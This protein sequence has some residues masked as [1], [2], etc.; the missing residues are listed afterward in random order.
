MVGDIS[1]LDNY[2]SFISRHHGRRGPKEPIFRAVVP[3]AVLINASFIYSELN[4]TIP[5]DSLDVVARAP[6]ENS[7]STADRG[8]GRRFPRATKD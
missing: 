1:L 7:I 5:E 3:F 4:I 6:A 2:V 8:S